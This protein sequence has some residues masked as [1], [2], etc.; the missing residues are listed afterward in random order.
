MNRPHATQE[1]KRAIWEEIATKKQ[2]LLHRVLEN[3]VNRL[4]RCVLNEGSH[5]PVRIYQKR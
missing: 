5:L 2:E 3:F 1:L 4:S